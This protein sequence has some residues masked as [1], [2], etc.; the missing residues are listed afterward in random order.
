MNFTDPYLVVPCVV[1]TSVNAPFI[2]DFKKFLDRSMGV[3]KGYSICKQLE[4]RY[5]GVHFVKIDNE[6]DGIY[7]V[8]RGELFGLIGTMPSIGYHLRQ[9]K[10]VDLKIAGKLPFDCQLSIATRKDEPVLGK[11]FE[12]LVASVS[13]KEKN[14]CWIHGSA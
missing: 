4:M 12:Q 14:N 11:I 5:P 3:V 13:D 1:A 8:Q 7:R 6:L 2:D 10:I 9:E